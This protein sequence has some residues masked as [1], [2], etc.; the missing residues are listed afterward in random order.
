LMTEKIGRKRE[1]GGTKTVGIEGEK[2]TSLFLLLRGRRKG[3]DDSKEGRLAGP[4]GGEREE[5]PAHGSDG[6]KWTSVYSP[7]EW[8]KKGGGRKKTNTHRDQSKGGRKRRLH[9]CAR[10]KGKASVFLRGWGREIRHTQKRTLHERFERAERREEEKKSTKSAGRKTATI[11]LLNRS[12]EKKDR[13]KEGKK[14]SFAVLPR[15]GAWGEK[16]K[17]TRLTAKSWEKKRCSESNGEKKMRGATRGENTAN[18][19]RFLEKADIDPWGG[20]PP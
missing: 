3:R 15:A 9:G 5:L 20:S 17:D 4:T 6:R 13:R 7:T 2:K 12:K 10:K 19:D 1:G 14:E 8:K 11:R 16:K 18:E